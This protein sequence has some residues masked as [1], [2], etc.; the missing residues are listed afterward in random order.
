I[1]TPLVYFGSY[2]GALGMSYG[3]IIGFTIFE[4]YIWNELK[5]NLDL[6]FSNEKSVW[7]SIALLFMISYLVPLDFKIVYKTII[8]LF[9]TVISI[10]N[11]KGNY[12]AFVKNEK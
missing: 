8:T 11:F 1:G 10:S 7:I 9:I 6:K 3:F 4:F 5:N 2:Y 12:L